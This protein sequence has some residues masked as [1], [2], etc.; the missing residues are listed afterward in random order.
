VITAKSVN[1]ANE[2]IDGLTDEQLDQEIDRLFGDQP[3]VL[4]FREGYGLG[5]GEIQELAILLTYFVF[6]ASEAENPGKAAT[7]KLEDFESVFDEATA[8]MAELERPEAPEC[9]LSRN[10]SGW[11]WA[12]SGCGPHHCHPMLSRLTAVLS[13]PWIRPIP[14]SKP[15]RSRLG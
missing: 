7:V 10:R 9:G 3:E 14:G 15:R 2:E 8:W 13:T 6:K 11:I 1:K 5:D 4:S 12:R